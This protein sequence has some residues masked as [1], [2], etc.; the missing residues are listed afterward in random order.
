MSYH[1]YTCYL[2]LY[3]FFFM[4]LT[5]SSVAETQ[6]LGY[7]TSVFCI[8]RCHYTEKAAGIHHEISLL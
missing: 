4:S 5:I 6:F 3:S 1:T 2:I 8:A 7:K